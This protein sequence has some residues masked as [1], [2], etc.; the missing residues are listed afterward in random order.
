MIRQMLMLTMSLYND[1][2]FA[3]INVCNRWRINSK[4]MVGFPG[5][6][7]TFFF[8]DTVTIGMLQISKICYSL[9]CDMMKKNNDCVICCWCDLFV[10]EGLDTHKINKLLKFIH[11]SSICSAIRSCTVS[12][13]SKRIKINKIQWLD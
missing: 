10:E 12:C 6:I 8:L 4:I 3:L 2:F 11:Q 1:V 13:F 9:V 7:L 5:R